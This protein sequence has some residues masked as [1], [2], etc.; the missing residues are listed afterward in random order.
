MLIRLIFKEKSGFTMR[1]ILNVLETEETPP[2]FNRSN[3]FTRVFQGIVD[4]YSIASYRE[5]NP[6]MGV[7]LIKKFNYEIF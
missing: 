3:K 5:I 6:G 7:F 2:T 1:P 4:S